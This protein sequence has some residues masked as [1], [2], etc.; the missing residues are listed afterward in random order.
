MST[1][2]YV[3]PVERAIRD[4]IARGEFDG[5]PGSGR[6]IPGVESE[7]DP[8]WWARR[9]LERAQVED[10]ADE[11]RRLIRSELPR[12]AVADPAETAARIAELDALAARVNEHLPEGDRIPPV[13]LPRAR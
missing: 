10:A 7:Y 6:P 12:L 5:L 3:G 8:D 11:V 1:D 9:W 2:E 4:A 13:R